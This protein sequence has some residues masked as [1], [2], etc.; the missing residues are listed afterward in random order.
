MASTASVAYIPRTNPPH[1]KDKCCQWLGTTKLKMN[2]QEIYFCDQQKAFYAAHYSPKKLKTTYSAPYY[3]KFVA[4][5]IADKKFAA[6]SPD[7]HKWFEKLHTIIQKHGAGAKPVVAIEKPDP[8]KCV[9]GA[10]AIGLMSR[11]GHSG[12]CTYMP[13]KKGII[14]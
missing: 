1:P 8:Y 5:L 2:T 7:Q 12:W 14:K 11:L 9:C 10:K 13:E 3:E 4:G 6:N